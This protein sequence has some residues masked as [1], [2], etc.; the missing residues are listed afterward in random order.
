[1]YRSFARTAMWFGAFFLLSSC[2]GIKPRIP[3]A[4]QPKLES[5]Q[6][7]GQRVCAPF[8]TTRY[9]WDFTCEPLPT[10][11]ATG[12]QLVPGFYPH[13]SIPNRLNRNR[14]ANITV[15][16]P[17]FTSI[18]IS[19]VLSN[20]S[21]S[22]QKQIDPRYGRAGLIGPVGGE[23]QVS[24]EDDGTR[25]TWHIRVVDNA[26]ND[27]LPLNI[28]NIS[29]N[30]PTRSNPLSV[31]LL[32]DPNDAACID[33]INHRVG[34]MTGIWEEGDVMAPNPN[35]AAVSGPCPDGSQPTLY[36]TCL[37]CPK[38]APK[39][40]AEYGEHPG[41]EFSDIINLFGMWP[42]SGKAQTCSLRQVRNQEECLGP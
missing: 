20:R 18:E 24:A 22:V 13:P 33:T 36:R 21:S 37:L 19:L 30:G 16:T 14:A 4:E 23:V 6:L 9:T 5:V 25:K 34:P 1:M 28:V 31:V 32:R 17:S 8:S 39:E 3:K 26:C 12:W 15:T 11:V 2:I 42:G 41:C 10:S 40:I 29:S 7:R 35:V 27:Q 38:N